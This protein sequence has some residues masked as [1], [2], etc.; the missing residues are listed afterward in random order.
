MRLFEENLI[1]ENLDKI[2][3]TS[4]TPEDYKKTINFLYGIQ[5]ASLYEL[6]LSKPFYQNIQ[7]IYLDFPEMYLNALSKL[8]Y[9]PSYIACFMD[10]C[11]NSSIWGTYGQNHSGVCLKFKTDS[12]NPTLNLKNNLQN[13]KKL[14]I[15]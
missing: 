9:P 6:A 1:I 10:N 15:V 4:S 13:P 12:S 7:N 14:L 2:K 5:K 8:I 11:T 3:W